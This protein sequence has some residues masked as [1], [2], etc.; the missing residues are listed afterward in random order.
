MQ[1]VYLM[2]LLMD[3]G[4]TGLPY[5]FEIWIQ[6]AQNRDRLLYGFGL[7][8]HILENTL[9][10]SK[11]LKFSS[12]APPRCSLIVPLTVRIYAGSTGARQVRVYKFAVVMSVY[13]IRFRFLCARCAVFMA[14]QKKLGGTRLPLPPKTTLV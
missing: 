8:I 10:S 14:P 2:D 7:W 9:Q 5:R 6:T 13:E 11:L 1:M 3:S 4:K 12:L